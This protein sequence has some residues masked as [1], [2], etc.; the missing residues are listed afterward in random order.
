MWLSPDEVP[1][2]ARQAFLDGKFGFDKVYEIKKARDQARALALALSRSSRSAM[3]EDNRN[4]RNGDGSGK[5]SAKLT[6]VRIPITA[7]AARGTAALDLPEGGDLAA[8]EKLLKEA[9][10]GHQPAPGQDDAAGR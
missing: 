6:R 8:L 2:E 3:R 9:K 5:P 4:Q 10:V 7:G 1:E